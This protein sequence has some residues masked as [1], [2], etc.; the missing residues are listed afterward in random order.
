LILFKGPKPLKPFLILCCLI[1]NATAI[2]A[3]AQNAIRACT[4]FA[5]A[6][7]GAK[8][9]ACIADL[10]PTGGIADATGFTGEQRITRNLFS[11]VK[12][13]VRLSLGAATYLVGVTQA[14]DCAGCEIIGMNQEAS[15]FRPAASVKKVVS[16]KSSS[17]IQDIRIDGSDTTDAKGIVL[18][19]GAIWSG[20]LV[21]VGITK[22]TGAGGIGLHAG[23]VVDGT[24]TDPV[25]ADNTVGVLFEGITD[26]SFPTT[27]R[28]F[29]GNLRTSRTKGVK[30][31]TGYQIQF[32]GTI[33]ESNLEEGVVMDCSR[34]TNIL[35]I[36][37]ISVWFEN[38]YRNN[39]SQYQFSSY[40]P[41]RTG[42]VWF[43]MSD[44]YTNQSAK[45]AKFAK[46]DGAGNNAFKFDNPRFTSIPGSILIQ[47][48]ASGYC[49]I[50]S[51]LIFSV[52]VTTVSGGKCFNAIDKL[53][54]LEGAWSNWTPAYSSDIGNAAATFRDSLVNTNV[55]R[56]QRVGKTLCLNI[57]Y[58]AKL[59]PTTPSIITVTMPPNTLPY[60][61]NHLP[62][63]IQ[64]NGVNEIG[65][66]TLSKKGILQF[67]RINN[68][69]FP[70][71]AAMMG[72]LDTCVEVQ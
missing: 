34:K 48:D 9:A 2:T 46:I 36:E 49:E 1:T 25:I 30:F 37:F 51:S 6:D 61:D 28:I 57:N 65:Y 70:A 23:D 17:K 4:S 62:V 11:G 56:Y 58:S 59:N 27:T 45:T 42:T 32:Y 19:D 64:L 63:F 68:A 66:A 35:N 69:P 16:L 55:S 44:T 71:D 26:G 22:F 20:Q 15:V 53:Q 39:T 33:I 5:G 14:I 38:N 41:V 24:I 29:G 13:P 54:A 60:T 67:T 43:T 12:K 8:I 72:I 31:V 52:V 50:P 47:N 21:R 10:P 18:G 3:L 7:A 40:C